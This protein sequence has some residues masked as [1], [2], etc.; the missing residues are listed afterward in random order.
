MVQIK[1]VQVN[2]YLYQKTGEFIHISNIS[3]FLVMLALMFVFF[4]LS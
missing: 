4:S 1:I 3:T 2:F